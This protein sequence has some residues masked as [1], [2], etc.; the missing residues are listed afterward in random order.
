MSVVE[1][2][3]NIERRDF[4]RL[5]GMVPLSLLAACQGSS[6]PQGVSRTVPAPVTIDM[7]LNHQIDVHNANVDNIVRTYMGR[8]LLGHGFTINP[9]D[10][11]QMIKYRTDEGNAPFAPNWVYSFVDIGSASRLTAAYS[12]FDEQNRLI[13]YQLSVD[14]IGKNYQPVPISELS[15]LCV[16]NAAGKFEIAQTNL[17]LATDVAFN[18]PSQRTEQY[19]LKS[20]TQL[21]PYHVYSA[22]GV[23]PDGKSFDVEGV[24]FGSLSLRVSV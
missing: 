3:R 10:V 12:R 1:Q 20:P 21:S 19:I 15:D 17:R 9:V 16:P 2:G 11:Q 5:L 4:L 7:R 13:G 24:P 23:T 22:S 18:L 8:A 6:R 14:A